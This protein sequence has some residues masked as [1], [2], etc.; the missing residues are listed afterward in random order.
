MEPPSAIAE[1]IRRFGEL[2][3]SEFRGQHRVIVPAETVH[4]ALAFLKEECNYQLLIDITCVDYL[5][6]EGAKDRFGVIYL[7]S[8]VD[9]NERVTLKT[10]VN[11]PEPELPTATDL[12]EGANWLERELWDMFGIRFRGHPDLRR[13]LLPE[14]FEAHPLR[15]DYPL[16]GYG[17]RHNLPRI[18]RDEEVSWEDEG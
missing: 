4:D 8:N 18:P 17:E 1:L 2:P 16:Q 14:G 3:V 13:I 15:K 7:L 5:Y 12:W 11:D 6:Y 9:T 10:F